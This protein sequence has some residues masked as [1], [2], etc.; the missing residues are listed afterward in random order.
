MY[1]SQFNSKTFQTSVIQ[2]YFG[3]STNKSNIIRKNKLKL[4]VFIIS[5]IAVSSSFS[6][7]SYTI[8]GTV[9]DQVDSL[10]F[11]NGLLLNQSDSSLIKGT[12][13]NNG[14]LYFEEVTEDTALLRI[15]SIDIADKY[16]LIIRPGGNEFDL[17]V[18]KV[19]AGILTDGVEVTALRPAF[20]VGNSGEI[21]VNVKGTILESSTSVND[22]LSKS[23]SV[24]VEEGNVSVFGKGEAIILLDGKLIS[25]AQLQAISV[26]N[27][28]HIE[29]LS[30]PPAK[31]DASG[32][33]VINVVLVDNPLEGFQGE[34]VQN[35]T[36]ARFLQSYTTFALNYRKK[37]L[38]LQ[39]SYG[40]DLG[41]NWGSNRLEREAFSN[42]GSTYSINDFEDKSNLKY[43]NTYNLG[44]TYDLNK[45]NSL[46]LEY[47]GSSSITDQDSKAETSFRDVTQSETQISTSNGGASSYLINSVN[48]NYSSVLD[49][50]GSN[51]FIGG[52]YFVFDSESESLVDEEITSSFVTSLFDRKNESQSNISFGTAQIDYQK[53]F[54]TSARR[55]EIGV[56]GISAD[57]SGIVDFFSKS[58]STDQYTH[59]PASSNDFKYLEMI[60][61]MYTQFTSDI[62]KKA[63]FS[64]GVRGEVT[65]ANGFSNALDSSVI[66]TSYF[67][68][69]PNM[70]LKYKFNG[71]WNANLSLSS[72]I[73]RPSY[74]ALDP[75]LFYVDTLTANQG[76]PSLRPEYAYSIESNIQYKRYSLKIGY[77]LTE[78]A[79]R[80]ALLQGNNGQSSSTL[81]QINVETEHSYFASVQIPLGF[82]K[83]LRSFNIIGATMD[84]VNDSRPEFSSGGV[85][86]RF[87]FFSNNM[88]N[89]GKAGKLQI[90]FRYMTTRYDGLY[91]RKPFMNLDLGW[92]KS[93]FGDKLNL[94]LLAGDLFHTNIVNGFYELN[95]SKVSYLR[96]MNTHLYRITIRF[97][98]GKLKEPGFSTVNIGKETNNRIRK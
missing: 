3:N 14:V 66:D 97:N 62:G 59:F 39:G 95:N 98:F 29:I 86:P 92:S 41:R 17:G 49:T 45:N 11:A 48:L 43:F 61:A 67:N 96:K 50:L 36:F 68:I 34:V 10:V 19:D 81:M 79:F 23:P 24:L 44:L 52:Q 26:S 93:F 47:T 28:D 56:K 60:G 87:Y 27:I 91:Y 16:F 77:T 32:K 57:N 72:S 38:S 74:Q 20:V 46:T 82:K 78:D 83:H 70:S 25:S 76:N 90:G 64:L 84:Q 33:A 2:Q 6:Q 51:L 53:N 15:S 5:I 22:L 80:Y 58:A 69:F 35:T 7:T 75:F 30:N 55:L 63:N 12:I 88:V 65:D 37:K 18:L 1:I 40:Q 8:K 42:L 71:K 54:K 85:I 13:I 4:Y 9:K 31:Y 73:N 89:L 21:N 94:S